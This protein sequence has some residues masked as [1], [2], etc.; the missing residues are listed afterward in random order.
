MEENEFRVVRILRD[1]YILENDGQVIEAV[2]SGNMKKRKKLIVGD[3]VRV[4]KNYDKYIIEEASERKN[5]L[6]R[7]PVANIDQMIIVLS[8]DNPLPDY[9]LLDKEIILCFSKNIEPI[10]CINKMDL[11]FSDNK[12]IEYIKNVYEKLG[13]KV[14]YTSIHDE[15]SINKLKVVLKGKVSAFSGNSGVGKSSITQKIIGDRVSVEIG[16]LGKK[17]NKGKH[18][19]KHVQLYTTDHDTYLLDTPG[20]SSYELYDVDHKELKKYYPDF[21]E[22]LCDYED[23]VHVIESSNVCGVKRKV[24]EGRIDK[25]RYDR[26]VYIYTKLKEQYDK[27]YK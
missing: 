15:D 13:F 7:P 10:L 21:S 2:T 3:I 8:I 25:E 9:M 19:T 1:R 23:C 26:Y 5:D 27:R 17:T 11:A 6:I 16:E 18:T 14:I 12:E 22:C 20:F 4:K 24:E